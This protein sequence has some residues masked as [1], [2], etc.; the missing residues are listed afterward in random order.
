MR[1]VRRGM[2]NNFARGTARNLGGKKEKRKLSLVLFAGEGFL[3]L[4]DRSPQTS[5]VAFG[6]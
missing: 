1:R 2:W 4:I 3:L 5:V 6:I